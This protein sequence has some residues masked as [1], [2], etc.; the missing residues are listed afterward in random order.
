MNHV[1]RLSNGAPPERSPHCGSLLDRGQSNVSSTLPPAFYAA[2]CVALTILLCVS[3]PGAMAMEAADMQ[4]EVLPP[5]VVTRT[6]APK[7]LSRLRAML[8]S[9][10]ATPPLSNPRGM[11][12]HPGITLTRDPV[13]GLVTG[14]V[15]VLLKPLVASDSVRARGNGAPRWIGQ[16]EGDSI[17]IRIN[18]AEPLQV[19]PDNPAALLHQPVTVGRWHGLPLLQVANATP[20]LV[21][22]A[23]GRPLWRPVTLGEHLTSRAAAGG[24]DAKA[25]REQ[26]AALNESGRSA[27]A[28]APRR[29]A[30]PAGDCSAPDAT[31]YVRWNSNYFDT[32]RRDAIQL[33][34]VRLGYPRHKET[35]TAY[36]T[37]HP[38]DPLVQALAAC[39]TFDWNTVADWVE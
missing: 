8:Q 35:S 30:E 18:D 10:L 7:V 38:T 23:T 37:A 6:T 39:E 3:G 32:T 5:A 36:R 4:G 24:P 2:R 34:T 31:V 9:L 1:T 11:S 33:M 27:P 19:E 14:S 26:L 21:I 12:V 29:R 16:G 25:A 13:N 17:E 22:A 28:C 20:V 15:R